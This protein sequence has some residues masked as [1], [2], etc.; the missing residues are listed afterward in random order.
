MNIN[1]I[2]MEIKTW[3]DF[4]VSELRQYGLLPILDDP[5]HWQAW[6]QRATEL[7]GLA[8][9]HPPNPY[10]FDSFYDWANRFNGAVQL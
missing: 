8:G 2:G 7:P 3:C 6:A 1:P 4:M 10:T 9:F 5:R